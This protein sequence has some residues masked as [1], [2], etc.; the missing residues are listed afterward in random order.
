MN[1]N[2]HGQILDEFSQNQN[3]LKDLRKIYTNLKEVDKKIS[4]IK[5][6]KQQAWARERLSGL[7][8]KE[9]EKADI[10]IGEEEELSNKKDQFQAKEK[11][12]ISYLN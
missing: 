3:L 8:Y 12:K 4:E 10:T 1:S 9:L 11:S 7:H 6:R 5:E 2:I